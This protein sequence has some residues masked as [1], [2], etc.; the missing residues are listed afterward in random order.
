VPDTSLIGP[1]DPIVR[2]WIPS[3][4][5]YDKRS[6]RRVYPGEPDCDFRRTRSRSMVGER[7]GLYVRRP[8][9]IE[10]K[11][12]RVDHLLDPLPQSPTSVQGV[13]W[14]TPM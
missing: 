5:V 8:Y 9:S 12:L 6:M 7:I 13:P 11:L 4:D 1:G 10:H 3:G 2:V 14:C